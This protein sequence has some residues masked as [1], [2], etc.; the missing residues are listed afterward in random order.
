MNQV[1]ARSGGGVVNR[2]V[3]KGFRFRVK[4]LGLRARDHESVRERVT[5]H[6]LG[7]SCLLFPDDS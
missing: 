2:V 5:R 3:T 7:A 4:G 1:G 6:A